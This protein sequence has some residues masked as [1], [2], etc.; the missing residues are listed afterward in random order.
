MPTRILPQIYPDFFL[1][2]PSYGRVSLEP[3]VSVAVGSPVSDASR[4]ASGSYEVINETTRK[5]RLVNTEKHQVDD[6]R[7]TPD[8]QARPSTSDLWVGCFFMIR[9]E[10][11]SKQRSWPHLVTATAKPPPG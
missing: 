7:T 5:Q 1:Q 6:N 4:R 3:L 9:I 8:P 2:W 11:L 10:A